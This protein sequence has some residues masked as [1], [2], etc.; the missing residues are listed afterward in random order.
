MMQ[1]ST[2]RIVSCNM[3]S[4]LVLNHERVG[5]PTGLLKPHNN[6][7][8][9]HL[10]NDNINHLLHASTLCLQKLDDSLAKE[11]ISTQAKR[12]TWMPAVERR[13][14][15]SRLGV[16]LETHVKPEVKT[17]LFIVMIC[18]ITYL[19]SK[20]KGE[21]RAFVTRVS[22]QETTL[23][24]WLTTIVVLEDGLMAVST[25]IFEWLLNLRLKMWTNYR[26]VAADNL[27]IGK[28]NQVSKLLAQSILTSRSF[29]PNLSWHSLSSLQLKAHA[30]VTRTKRHILTRLDILH[31][32]T[33][34]PLRN[35]C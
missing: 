21:W 22:Q 32:E 18:K 28:T 15:T 25:A 10:A 11:P 30:I 24:F 1:S 31:L 4:F 27:L 5:Y 23:A 14:G 2:T 29:L 8:C 35:S 17:K 13:G 20:T 26:V 34:C 12:A 19:Q 33:R 3:T 9:D 16:S 6:H 7:W